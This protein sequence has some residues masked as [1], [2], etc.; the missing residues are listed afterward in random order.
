MKRG[1]PIP[2][3]IDGPI[4]LCTRNDDLEEIIQST[5]SH[6]KSNLVFLQNGMLGPYLKSKSLSDNTQGLVYFAVAKKGDKPIDGKTDVN[7][8]VI[9][10]IHCISVYSSIILTICI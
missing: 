8:E 7:P 9:L 10:N 1:D 5:P 2:S 3:I 6:M 4:Y